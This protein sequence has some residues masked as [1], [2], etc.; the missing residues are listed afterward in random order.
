MATFRIF[1]QIYLKIFLHPG[2]SNPWEW[3]LV[4]GPG[5]VRMMIYLDCPFKIKLRSYIICTYNP[6]HYNFKF[7]GFEAH[8]I[9]C[10]QEISLKGV[11]HEIF[12]LQFFSCFEPI[13]APDKQAKVFLNS[14]LISPRYTIRKFEKFDSAVCMTQGSKHFR[15]S[16]S[17]NFL[18]I[19]S[20]IIDGFTHKLISNDYP[21]K[22]NQILTKISILTSRCAV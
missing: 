19:F 13:W 15:L 18:L 3:S 10:D 12:D 4:S 6:K 5:W 9:H 8:D 16:Q 7:E 22:S 2:V 17:K 11:C 1:K 14:V 21:F 20:F